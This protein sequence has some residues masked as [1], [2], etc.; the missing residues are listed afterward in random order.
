ML[1][2][3]KTHLGVC[4][5]GGAIGITKGLFMLII[6]LLAWW[7][8]GWASGFVHSLSTIYAGYHA[9][10]IGGVLAGAGWG[11]LCGFITGAVIAFFYNVLLHL[12]CHCCKKNEGK[13][14]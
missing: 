2:G 12:C 13:C 3:E 11:V 10:T 8:V 6:G 5:F 9:D 14:E 1:H 4:C 7:N